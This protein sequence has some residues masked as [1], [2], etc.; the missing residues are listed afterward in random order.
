MKNGPTPS[1]PTESS[2][3]VDPAVLTSVTAPAAKASGSVQ[4]LARGLTILE[5]V[6]K[7]PE[8]LSLQEVADA[9]DVA[10]PTAFNLTA[11]LIAPGWLEKTARPVRYRLGQKLRELAA[12]HE[13]ST[14]EGAGPTRTMCRAAMISVRERLPGANVLMCQAVGSELL[15]ILRIEGSR[16]DVIQ[17]PRA[18]VRVPYSTATS[19]CFLAFANTQE[20][21]DFQMRNPFSLYGA[22]LWGTEAKLEEFLAAS[23][24]QG[25]AVPELNSPIRAA[26]PIYGRNNI[27]WGCI[28][29]SLNGDK[30]CLTDDP[31]ASPETVKLRIVEAVRAAAAEMSYR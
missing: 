29:A 22:G 23:R 26:A 18:P 24:R 6:S 10:V 15:A 4:S 8:G 27:L 7:A 14:G 16:Q 2:H 31:D 19:L 30:A 3:A 28:G 21:H 11:T 13:E 20:R 25:Y 9:L 5:L 1:F 12:A 17:E